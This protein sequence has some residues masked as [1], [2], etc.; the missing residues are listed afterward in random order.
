MKQKLLFSAGLALRTYQKQIEKLNFIKLTSLLVFVGIIYIPLKVYSYQPEGLVANTRQA[1]EQQ[2]IKI[3]GT[4]ADSI[5]GE[6]LAGVNIRVEGTAL[7]TITDLDGKYSI[8]GPSQTSVLV[9]SYIR[10]FYSKSSCFG[11]DNN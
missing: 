2:K 5:T 9:F 10:I 6:M 1:I 3:T 11:P 7:G 4:I 8:K